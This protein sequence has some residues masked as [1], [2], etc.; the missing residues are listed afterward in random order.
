[1]YYK[2]KITIKHTFLIALLFVACSRNDR[3]IPQENS[4]ILVPKKDTLLA[5]PSS[6]KGTSVGEWQNG[7]YTLDNNNE[8]NVW[9]YSPAD[10]PFGL[11]FG[12]GLLNNGKVNRKFI[13]YTSHYLLLNSQLPLASIK[14]DGNIQ[15]LSQALNTDSANIRPSS[16]AWTLFSPLKIEGYFDG[17]LQQSTWQL[18]PY[19]SDGTLIVTNSQHLPVLLAHNSPLNTLNRLDFLLLNPLNQFLSFSVEEKVWVN[20]RNLMNKRP[21][22][23]TPQGT[24]HSYGYF[25]QGNFYKL[26]TVLYQNPTNSPFVLGF[27]GFNLRENGQLP[28]FNHLKNTLT[29]QLLTSQLLENSVYIF[30]HDSTSISTKKDRTAFKNQQQKL[31]KKLKKNYNISFEKLSPAD[32]YNLEQGANNALLLN[33]ELEKTGGEKQASGYFLATL[34]NKESDSIYPHYIELNFIDNLINDIE[35]FNDYQ[36]LIIYFIDNNEQQQKI[37]F[38]DINQINSALDTLY[39]FLTDYSNYL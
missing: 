20:L 9:H 34:K 28:S 27:Q 36:N 35:M 13:S 25:T 30:N 10:S 38:T 29:L 22:L 7:K 18:L 5:S 17:K 8:A 16:L 6:L 33:I 4:T 1:M 3:A 19:T 23:P 37:I 15:F 12:Y 2:V 21:S 31:F 11:V 14:P 32:R 24:W 39:K 26:Q